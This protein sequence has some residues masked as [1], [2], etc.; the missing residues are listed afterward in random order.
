MIG[1]NTNR[2]TINK[3]AM[4]IKLDFLEHFNLFC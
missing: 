3:S 1:T 4:K 2:A